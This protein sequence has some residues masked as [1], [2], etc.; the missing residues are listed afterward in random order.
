MGW[1]GDWEKL[2]SREGRKQAW[3]LYRPGGSHF[4]PS[5][6]PRAPPQGGLPRSAFPSP[7]LTPSHFPDL[8]SSL[9]LFWFWFLV[10]GFNFLPCPT[11]G[12]LST[13]THVYVSVSVL[14]LYPLSP[15]P[16]HLLLPQFLG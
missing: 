5:S 1:A 3:V 6:V 7:L 4:G 2:T 13:E 9:F 15:F 11:S 12:S 8:F 14:V 10:F 16:T